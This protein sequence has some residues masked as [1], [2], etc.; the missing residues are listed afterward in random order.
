MVR[1]QGH[2]DRVSFRDAVDVLLEKTEDKEG[3]VVLSKEKAERLKVWDAV[4]R[5]YETGEPVVGRGAGGRRPGGSSSASP[6]R[7]TCSSR[8]SASQPSLV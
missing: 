2:P 4:E 3:Y 5:A 8:T 7:R 1:V 6:E